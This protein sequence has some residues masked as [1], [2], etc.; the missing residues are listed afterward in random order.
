MRSIVVSALVLSLV[1]VPHADAAERWTYAASEHFEA[2]ATGGDRKAREALTYFERVRAFF[3]Q[4]LGLSPQTARP[5]RLIIFSGDKQFAPYSP[6]PLTAAFYQS[7][8]DRDYIVMQSLDEDSYPIVVH[9]YA[10]LIVKHSGAAYPLWLNEGLAE[11]FSTLEPEGGRMSVGKVPTDR[12]LYLSDGVSMMELDRLFGV[13]HD[14]PE[15]VGRSHAGVF[16]SQSWALTH[17]LLV[18]DR[19]RPKSSQFLRQIEAG[20]PSA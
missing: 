2:Y 11:F 9:E 15:Y 17:M 19:Y 6:G 18:D 20:T 12:L 13:K 10:H 7:G 4:F 16:Y 3:A 1:P 5:T 8:P 14:S